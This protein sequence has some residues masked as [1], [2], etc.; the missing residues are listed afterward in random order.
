MAYMDDPLER[1]ILLTGTLAPADDDCACAEVIFAETLPADGSEVNDCAC[2]DSAGAVT[3][4]QMRPLAY[5]KAAEFF[6]LALPNSFHLALPAVTPLGP[7]VLNETA[8][9]V[10]DSFQ[11]PHPIVTPLE[12]ALAKAGLLCAAG[13]EQAAL[14]DHAPAALTAWLHVTNACNLDCPYCYVRKSSL[15]MPLETGRKALG[16]I[17]QTAGQRGLKQVKLKY[18]GGEA[19]LHFELVRALHEAAARLSQASG[20]KL[21]EVVLSNGTCLGDGEADWF[22]ETGARLMISLDGIGQ[23]H[24]QVRS[25]RAGLGTFAGVEQVIDRVLLPKGVRP[26]ISVTISKRN[27]NQ[28]AQ[29]V[30]WVLERHL[31]L[32][33]NF[34]RMKE[35]GEANDALS[36]DAEQIIAGMLEAYATIEAHLPEQPFLNG[37]LDRV[38]Y[39]AHAMTC[40]VGQDYLVISPAGRLAQCHMRLDQAAE[41]GP[42]ANLLEMTRKGEMLNLPVEQKTGCRVCLFR[43]YCSGGCPLETYR[44]SGRWDQ[45]SPNCQIYREL[46]PHALRLEGLRLMKNGGYL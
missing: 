12:Q 13:E 7:T 3:V 6:S 40:G 30:G 33:L 25:T 1:P 21:A 24:D 4:Q 5:Q 22:A 39:G 37:L 20:I 19:T 16:L 36:R 17:F 31:P 9:A 29:I 10:L 35:P 45:P 18:A 23:G 46:I 26:T 43:Y 41:I 28:T 34:Y 8:W 11:S 14:A 15:T 44:V 2:A 38:R 42:D 32:S 27:A